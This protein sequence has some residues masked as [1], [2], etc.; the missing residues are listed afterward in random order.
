MKVMKKRLLACSASSADGSIGVN[1]ADS[2]I[3]W[4]QCWSDISAISAA[5]QLRLSCIAPSY[6][7]ASQSQLPS[8]GLA[9]R[10]GA[11]PEDK[12]EY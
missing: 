5:C 2:L 10:A 12:S 11:S 6:S 9:K 1:C 7:T 4:P 8:L 3:K